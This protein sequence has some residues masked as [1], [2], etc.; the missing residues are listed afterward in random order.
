MWQRL[1]VLVDTRND[2]H[3]ERC[4]SVPDVYLPQG[5]YFGLSAATGDLA[6]NHDIISFKVCVCARTGNQ[7]SMNAPNLKTHV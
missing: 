6:D 5:Y 2:D 1:D 3:W 4:F 7:S